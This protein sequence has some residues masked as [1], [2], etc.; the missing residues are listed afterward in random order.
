VTLALEVARDQPAAAV[1]RVR[2]T[3]VGIPPELM[4]GIFEPFVQEERSLARSQGGLGLG[5]ALVKGIA[6]LHGGTVCVESGGP[7]QGAEF[8]VRLPL[9]ENAVSRTEPAPDTRPSTRARR[10]L[11]VD[12]NRD[13]AETLAELIEM[14]GY[15]AEATYDG[16]SALA[17]I[18]ANPP[19]IVLCDIGLPGMDGYQLAGILRADRAK[20][21]RLIAVS[22]YAQPEDL[23]RSAEAGF[24]AH[25]A[26][27]PDPA[28]LKRL[29]SSGNA[30]A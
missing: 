5:L 14:L 28:E 3:G 13:G 15:D 27:P 7:D 11:I 4:G 9:V 23:K 20:G 1:I 2:D 26:K 17:K 12:D 10:V 30:S 24:D 25:V 21:M 19:D 22:G 29:L 8:I 6:E 18:R 16:P